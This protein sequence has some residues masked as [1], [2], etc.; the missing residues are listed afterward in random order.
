MKHENV[1]NKMTEIKL[2]PKKNYEADVSNTGPSSEPSCSN[3]R[4]LASQTFNGGNLAVINLES[5]DSLLNYV[6]QLY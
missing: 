6:S 1:S 3:E 4:K 2:P 5:F